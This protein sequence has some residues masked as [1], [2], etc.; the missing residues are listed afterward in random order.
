METTIVHRAL[1]V[2]TPKLSR[3]GECGGFEDCQEAS[4]VSEDDVMFGVCGFVPYW[5]HAVGARIAQQIS[6]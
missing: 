5:D 6:R 3:P 2:A 4:T 1:Q